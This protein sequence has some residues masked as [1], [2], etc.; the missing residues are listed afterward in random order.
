[1]P[2]PRCRATKTFTH[3]LWECKVGWWLWKRVWQIYKY[4]FTRWPSSCTARY[5]PMW[6]EN[7]CSTKM[8]IEMFIAAFFISTR[9]WKQSRHLS[10]GKYINTGISIHWNLLSNIKEWT[11]D[12]YSNMDGFLMYSAK[13]KEPDLEGYVFCH[14]IDMTL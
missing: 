11:V 5:F 12:A 2:I 4:T 13:W 10:A 9:N 8:C 14:C 6:T 1:M 7:L 3:F